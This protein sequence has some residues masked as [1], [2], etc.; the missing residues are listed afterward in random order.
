MLDAAVLISV[1]LPSSLFVC[2][3]FD[4]STVPHYLLAY[5]VIV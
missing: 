4:M 3:I 5:I 2:F 1:K